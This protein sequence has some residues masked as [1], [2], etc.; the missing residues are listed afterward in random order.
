MIRS[1]FNFQKFGEDKYLITNYAGRYAF[2]D[3]DEFHAFCKGEVL[4]PDTLN[5]LSESFFCTDGNSEKF[6]AE[7]SEAIREYRNYLF[8]G[9]G[10]HI[11]VLTEKCNM[12]CVYCQASTNENGR[13]MSCETAEKCVDFALSSPNKY[14][15][16]EFQG[17]EP[18]ENFETLK[19]IVKY[20]KEKS[21]GKVIEYNLVS[22]LTML[23]DEMAEF[24]RDNRIN[25]STSLDGD[26]FL[27]NLNRPMT[28]ENGYLGWK[29][30]Y[31]KLKEITGH[32]CGAI[33]TTT[34]NSFSRYKEIIDEYIENDFNR[35]FIRPLTPLGYAA[36]RW[37]I[38]GYTAEEFIEFYRKS[39][40]YILEKC[41]Q[42]YNIAEGH[43]CIFLNKILNHRAGSY[44]E[45][46]SPCG[47][48]LGQLA[49][50]YDG[51]IYSCD[52]GRMMAEM[53]DKTF[54]LGDVNTSYNELFESPTCKLL[55]NASCLECI[56]QCE[57]CV[58][59]PY[60][61]TCPV[62]NY[63]ESKT[64]FSNEPNGYKCKIYKGILTIIFEKLLYGN[65]NEI[66]I[67]KNWAM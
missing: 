61:G 49:Y 44:T 57:Q 66:E 52:E 35:I 62:L 1:D 11:F 23:N 25:V 7:Y 12:K 26:A 27:Q 19:H 31:L 45:L 55:A 42:G 48:A 28:G 40:E 29:K 18:L 54:K 10:L 53:G 9:T 22:N 51:N 63:F 58:F 20:S 43:A 36:Q 60:C 32:G 13:M 30:N 39:F 67:L 33:Q 17:G 37:K 24:I 4:H 15:S 46:T 41:K 2:L 5:V 59:S 14:I 64:A 38:I 3:K 6:I 65:D 21:N 34:K 56:P 16:F 8:V 50:N 47:A